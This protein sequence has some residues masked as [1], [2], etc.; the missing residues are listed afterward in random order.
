MDLQK[1]QLLKKELQA[2]AKDLEEANEGASLSDSAYKMRK[3]SK[4]LFL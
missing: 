1:L 4:A 2:E 3:V